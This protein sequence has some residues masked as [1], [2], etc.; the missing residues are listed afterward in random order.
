MEIELKNTKQKVE[1]LLNKFP[2]LRD[3]DQALWVHIIRSEI[4]WKKMSGEDVLRSISEGKCTNP[5]SVRRCRAKINEYDVKT[6]GESY[7][8]R[9]FKETVIREEIRNL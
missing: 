2:K 5:E 7:K 8:R 4:D 1:F 6:R 9:H 3:S